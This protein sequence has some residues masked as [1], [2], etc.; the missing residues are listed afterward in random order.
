MFQASSEADRTL[1]IRKIE[2]AWRQIVPPA[3]GA[4]SPIGPAPV[5][6]VAEVA[7]IRELAGALAKENEVCEE[8]ADMIFVVAIRLVLFLS[9]SSSFSSI[10]FVVV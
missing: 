4:A 5:A 1:W 6:T 7:E 2:H 9:S 3:R 10:A 8:I